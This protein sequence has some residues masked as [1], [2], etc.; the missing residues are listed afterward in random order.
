MQGRF[1]CML[2]KSS[3]N[4][5]TALI[6]RIY[7][8]ILIYNVI[9]IRLARLVQ[10]TITENHN[11]P[12]N[13]ILTMLLYKSCGRIWYS[14]K[15]LQVKR[16]YVLYYTIKV[17]SFMLSM[18]LQVSISS[19]HFFLLYLVQFVFYNDDAYLDDNVTLTVNPEIRVM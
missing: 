9:H 17:E 7:L 3:R 5:F 15:T 10:K 16:K 19:L 18:S 14:S 13:I 11:L 6:G 1:L 12:A 4:T 2:L 8:F